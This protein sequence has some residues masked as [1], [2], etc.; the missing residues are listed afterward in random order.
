ML[1]IR[2]SLIGGFSV[3]ESRA[4]SA[5]LQHRRFYLFASETA[6]TGGKQPH[7]SE[8]QLSFAGMKYPTQTF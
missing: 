5:T 1:A 7:A 2:S 3:V 8:A 4:G 6:G